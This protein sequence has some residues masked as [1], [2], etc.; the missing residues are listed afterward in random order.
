M[1]KLSAEDLKKELI[2]QKKRAEAIAYLQKN[3]CGPSNAEKSLNSNSAISNVL[4]E[5]NKAKA[6][7]SDN[8]LDLLLKSN[9]ATRGA[10]IQAKLT[11]LKQQ[12]ELRF[13]GKSE[14]VESGKIPD[15]WQ[16]VFDANSKKHYFWNKI[17]NETK[18]ERPTI[19]EPDNDNSSLNFVNSLPPGWIEVKHPPTS[20]IYY[21]H[22]AT[23]EKR[24][25]RPVS[26]T[27]DSDIP[28]SKTKADE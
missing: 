19:K 6:A 23:G 20:Q 5:I 9:A 14:S 17:T 28:K 24:W 4:S 27:D 21:V 25:T 16:E 22:Q 1:P 26:S 3:G 7:T 8:T 12:D 2:A 15:G 13:N 10:E 18:W 11:L